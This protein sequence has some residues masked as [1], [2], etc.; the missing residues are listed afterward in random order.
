VT[1]SS[2]K[3]TLNVPPSN[4]YVVIEIQ[5]R[6]VIIVFI[7]VLVLHCGHISEDTPCRSMWTESVYIN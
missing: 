4:E 2:L 1:Q 7:Y 5:E 6:D 3:K